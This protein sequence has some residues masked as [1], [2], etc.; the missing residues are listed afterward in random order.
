MSLNNIIENY[1]NT[2]KDIFSKIDFDS[3]ENAIKIIEKTISNDKKI[4]TFG[5]GGSAS[6]AQHFITDWN[7]MA[8]VNLK[9]KVKGIS[10]NDN[11]GIITAYGNDLNFDKI[12]SEQIKSLVDKDDLCIAISIS[13]NSNN[14]LEGIKEAKNIK[15]STLSLTGFDG[16]KLKELTDNYI[17]VPCYD[18][19]ICEDIHL[20][21]GH[22]IMKSIAT[23][24]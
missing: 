11:M 4:I 3:I 21:I 22:I 9:K 23:K 18:M 12:F 10:L 17:H 5:N 14:V 1:F 7:K 6:T 13:G 8:N 20:M 16:G 2:H 19:Q 15:A 24:K